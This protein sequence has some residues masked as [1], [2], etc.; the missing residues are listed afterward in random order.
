MS[1]PSQQ[2]A[3]DMVDAAATGPGSR[4]LLL[5][6]L[7]HALPFG[8][9]TRIGLLFASLVLVKVVLVFGFAKHVYEKHWRV[10]DEPESWLNHATF[11]LFL[12]LALLGLLSLATHCRKKGLRTVRS[13]N[14]AILFLGLLFIF[15]T[16]R[17]GDKNYLYP[18]MIGILKWGSLVPYLSL[19]LFFRPPF[20]AAWMLLYAF[21]YY[22]MA[23]SGR[24]D[25]TLHLTAVVAGAYALLCLR[26]L[27]F[28]RDELLAID[29]IGIGCVLASLGGSL[30]RA[31]TTMCMRSAPRSHRFWL[32]A[33]ALWAA[34]YCA[35]LA[36]VAPQIRELD[37]YFRLLFGGTILLF[38]GV[39]L[40]A[41][42]CDFLLPWS[43]FAP[44][45]FVTFLLLANAYYPMA[46][47]YNNSLCLA[48]EFPHYFL[49][50]LMLALAV[51]VCAWACHLFWPKAG[52]KWLDVVNV[53]FIAIA[54]VD[55]RLS[56]IMG[57][58]LEWDVLTFG[59]SPKMMWRMAKPYLPGVLLGLG[60]VVLIY[61]L[62]LYGLER[63][64]QRRS[65]KGKESATLSHSRSRNLPSG[66]WFAI[67]TF[68][69][70]ALLGWAVAEPDKAEGESALRLAASSPLWNRALNRTLSPQ[71]F[72]KTADELGLS[73]EPANAK[74]VDKAP[75]DLNVLVV[76]M[77]S[78]Y[79]KYL[80]LFGS[81]YETQ[82]LLSKYKERME[83]FPNFFS[84]FASSIHAR[85][86]AFT[87]LY[88]ALDYNDFTL[89]RVNVKS[90]FEVLHENGYS[91]SLFYSS[92]FDFTD[93][94]DFLKERG[95][96]EMYDANNMPG[97]RG[98]EG[99][100]WGLKEETTLGAI[101]GQ[102][103]KYA[104]DKQR[105][106]LTYVPAAPHYPYDN[107]PA[108]FRKFKK[109]TMND[110]TPVYLN[111]LLY[112][113][114]VLAS[115]VDELRESGLL[116]QTL[117]I[118]TNDHGEMLGSEGSPIGH[119]WAF[120]PELAN[121]PLIVMDPQNPG[122]HINYT[123]GSQVDFLPSVL[124]RLNIPLPSGQL[125]EG[126]SLYQPKNHQDRWVYLNTCQQF[127]VLQ[128]NQILVGDR[129]SAGN[130][131]P[132]S[133]TT[134]FAISNQEAR[135][136][137]TEA[138]SRDIRPV[139]IRRFDDFQ[140]NLLRNYSV[141][142]QSVCKD[143]K[144]VQPKSGEASTTELRLSRQ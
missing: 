26:E 129:D 92:F 66:L 103:K 43:Q 137:F 3:D 74:P 63:W 106:F 94:G 7:V 53:V 83:I 48:L 85:F 1:V 8:A 124:D 120:T 132:G 118:I 59:N 143:A 139:S 33:P 47:N 44:F 122:C 99:V 52:F 12:V 54:L 28:F 128:G 105:F 107:I 29:C 42:F 82:P 14:A 126:S 76:F 46:H 108:Q 114:W 95:I 22:L 6:R 20:L 69:F 133:K 115:I 11:F 16:F 34:V 70:L 35:L 88:P 86:A 142:C 141:Y 100:S 90:L 4:P 73:F 119:G 87:S 123:I 138:S 13:A 17:T 38:A 24:E 23:R 109:V 117:V 111:E 67:A 102:I 79:N 110:Y 62:S 31:Q 81:E 57:V 36:L 96:D 121:T 15:L 58:R 140:Q 97:A 27:H 77:E 41:K 49:G 144:S 56:Q 51:A 75:R 71:E 131:N 64:F 40:W 104:R 2:H 32:F 10:T 5:S 116:D 89:H 50:E 19:D 135:T 127:G 37:L 93:F 30:I 72:I 25:L 113:D 84:V 80:S 21:V 112:M 55:L 91:C 130:R 98:V 61:N 9:W 60:T 39:T 18:I 134:S 125:Y 45:C 101:R 68:L 78:S 65:I 136:V